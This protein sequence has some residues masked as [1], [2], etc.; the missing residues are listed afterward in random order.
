RPC[1]LEHDPAMMGHRALETA[2]SRHEDAYF[3][4]GRRC[5]RGKHAGARPIGIPPRLRMPAHAPRQSMDT[6]RQEKS[7]EEEEQETA[8]ILHDTPTAALPWRH[9]G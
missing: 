8:Q 9:L 2:G 7:Q 4:L 1:W 3:R 5:C 6:R